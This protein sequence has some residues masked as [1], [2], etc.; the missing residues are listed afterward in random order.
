MQTVFYELNR[1]LTRE[2]E[3][4]K[5]LADV[6]SIDR[7]ADRQ[8][9][10]KVL[11]EDSSLWQLTAY[12]N[13]RA[14]N[15]HELILYAAELDKAFKETSPGEL[16]KEAE[17][18]LNGHEWD[19]GVAM[20]EIKHDHLWVELRKLKKEERDQ[21]RQKEKELAEA[22]Q[23]LEKAKLELNAQITKEIEQESKDLAWK[24]IRN[25]IRQ[26]FR[27]AYRYIEQQFTGEESEK[28]LFQT[29]WDTSKSLAFMILN[30][31]IE[32]ALFLLFA[33][34]LVFLDQS[35]LPIKW[36][37]PSWLLPLATII[38]GCARSY[39]KWINLI[40]ASFNT[41]QKQIEDERTR[42]QDTCQERYNK[43]LA[44]QK[45]AYTN[46]LQSSQM[47]PGEL[48]DANLI[49][50]IE[51]R[52]T[53][54]RAEA[55]YFRHRVGMTAGFVSL[56]DFVN[57]RLDDA[58]YEKELGLMHQVQRD[59]QELSDSLTADTTIENL[60]PRGRPR[61]ILY[62]D[63]LD[64]CPPH[65]VVEV[66]EAVQLLLKTDLFIVV[67]A[68]DARFVT[69]ALEASYSGILTRKGSPSGLDYIEKII[70]IP[71][72][73]QPIAEDAVESFLQAQM[74]ASAVSTISRTD[75]QQADVETSLKMNTIEKAT[76]VSR[77]TIG[78]VNDTNVANIP[79]SE[80]PNLNE[81]SVHPAPLTEPDLPQAAIEISDAEF[82]SLKTRC[83]Q[84]P[85]TPRAVKR[86]TNVYKLIKIIWY[87][88]QFAPMD[89]QK[90]DLIMTLLTLSEQYPNQMRELF[91]EITVDLKKAPDKPI[92]DLFHAQMPKEKISTYETR[93]WV[94]LL[95]NAK[96][97]IPTSTSLKDIDMRTFMLVR[98]FCFVGDIGYE[99]NDPAL[100]DSEQSTSD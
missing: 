55:I 32:F 63:D 58:V 86:I 97:L 41:Y 53:K 3:I 77:E 70:Q 23:K 22:Q 98:A 88:Q 8:K 24:P 80:Y 31:P 34:L 21:L 52:V 4:A 9:V 68:I 84:I 60:F 79:A 38:G 92:L 96:A 10:F 18:W 71:Y 95:L 93:Q 99:A 50:A 42:L 15:A 33:V 48:V 89:R 73:V 35:F 6:Q 94:Q 25:L 7:E 36:Q 64:R 17:R 14:R 56:L 39:N 5:I 90:I 75:E 76:A 83:E 40:Q 43:S 65:R 2:N 28:S 57:S 54:L 51:D 78:K 13:L 87:R 11:K 66:L 82:Q 100:I 47:Q 67:L 19:D 45:E 85:M 69:R 20:T 27:L 44:A 16:R 62:I 29:I 61:I 30:N 12:P 26:Q 74:P 46:K 81:E 72:M 49:P 37:L 91:Q 1:Q 59:L